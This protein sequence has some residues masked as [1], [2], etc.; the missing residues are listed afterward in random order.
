MHK[1]I[2]KLLSIGGFIGPIIYV[3][4]LSILGYLEPGYNHTTQYMSE[5]AAVNAPNMFWM[6]LFGF[7][8]LGILLIG[9]GF[10]LDKNIK[11]NRWG[12]IGPYLII[13]S[14]VG[15]VLTGLFP[16][17]PGCENTSLVGLYHGLWAFIAQFALIGAPFFMFFRLRHDNQWSNYQ[18]ISMGFFIS[19]ITLGL[20]YKS[21]LFDEYVGLLQR[22][23]FGIPFLW[24][25]IMGWKNS[26]HIKQKNH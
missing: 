1:I 19:G 22:I 4:I 7:I 10:T 15:L 6:N 25:V 5:L 12:F 9:F 2:F 21:Y 18:W 23:S 8:L 11:K 14:G 3:I 20:I 17:D 24:V 26:F 16:C 13:V